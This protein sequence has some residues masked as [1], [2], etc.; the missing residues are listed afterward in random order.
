MKEIIDQLEL[1]KLKKF[2]HKS[3][4]R[5]MRRQEKTVRK[6]LQKKCLMNDYYINYTN[7]S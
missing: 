2:S 7:N 4:V 6:Y 1:I 5:R 3:T